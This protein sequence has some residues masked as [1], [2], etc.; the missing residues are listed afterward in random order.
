MQN[1]INNNFNEKLLILC[2]FFKL[3]NLLDQI[4]NHILTFSHLD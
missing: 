1:E 2:S 3:K 4:K